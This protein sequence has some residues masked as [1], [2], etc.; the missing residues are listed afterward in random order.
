MARRV[1]R[2]WVCRAIKAQRAQPARKDLARKVCRVFKVRACKA[3]RAIRDMDSKARQV[4]RVIKDHAD[5]SA[6]KVY[7][8]GKDLRAMT[9][10]RD[11]KAS[12][13]SD[14]RAYKDRSANKAIKDS[15]EKGRKAAKEQLAQLVQQAQESKA[16]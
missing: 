2:A 14:C 16:R 3:L 5:S 6:W 8:D 1:C 4:P 10:H 7:K 12:P 11:S 15:R 9:G 13:V